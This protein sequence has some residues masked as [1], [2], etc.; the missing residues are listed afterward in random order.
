MERK[1]IVILLL[2]S[3]V[4]VS[5]CTD[6]LTGGG[7]IAQGNV[8]TSLSQSC[9]DSLTK[10]QNC[11]VGL[12]GSCDCTANEER[13]E[14]LCL[15]CG[16]GN[17]QS[18]E[19]ECSCPVDCKGNENVFVCNEGDRQTYMCPNNRTD[20][21]WCVCKSNSWD[22]PIN[23]AEACLGHGTCRNDS[24]CELKQLCINEICED[25]CKDNHSYDC[26][27]D[28][29]Y[30][31]DSCG[32]LGE[33]K[34]NC[35]AGCINGVCFGC[36]AEDHVDC[37]EGDVWWYDSCD[38]RER[39]YENCLGSCNLGECCAPNSTFICHQGDIHWVDA[40]NVTQDDLKENCT[41]DHG[42]Y[43]E[44]NTCVICDTHVYYTCVN[45][46]TG[47]LYWYNSCGDREDI[48]TTCEQGCSGIEC[49]PNCTDPD[50]ADPY[51]I[52]TTVTDRH[53]NNWTDNC[54]D[55]RYINEYYCSATHDGEYEV[56]D[57]G[58]PAFANCT[59]GACVAV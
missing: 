43:V 50:V 30:W 6:I 41:F 31:F 14:M 32:A 9:C 15:Q 56:V 18:D 4:A 26:V 3:V 17:C 21:E 19:N 27:A 57:C 23:P 46:D 59:A 47:D 40:C 1:I 2:F 42:C 24:D 39:V 16:D 37:Y 25:L 34:E 29:V 10:V 54:E 8:A 53:G 35:S 13:G 45:G 38:I 11:F 36:K 33:M 22:C 7:C 55:S 44:N 58:L 52:A 48:R 20:I 28:N 5:G 51:L 49:L 12:D